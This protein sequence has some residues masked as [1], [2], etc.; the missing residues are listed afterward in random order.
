MAAAGGSVLNQVAE[1]LGASEPALKLILSIF[2]GYPLALFQRYFL[3][4][5]EPSHIHLFNTV[6]GLGIA[7][8]NFG[9]Q[10]YHSLLCVVLNFLILRLMGRTITAVLTSFCFQMG[11]LLCGYYY[12]ATENYDIKWTMPQ[13]VLTLK[14]IGLT[15]D[16]YDGGKEQES[17]TE[18]QKRFAVPGVPSLIEV[19]GFSYYYGG[20]LVGPQF[21]MCSYLKLVRGELTDVPGQRP[22]S[23]GP[24]MNRLCLGLFSLVIYTVF[25][26]HLPDSYF[27]TDEFANQPFWYRCAYIPIWGKVILYKY[28]TCWLVTEGVCI[29]SGLGYNGKDDTG[30]AQWDAC[31]NMK[32]W[33]FETTP[34]FTGT[35]SSF[36]INTNAWVARYIFKRLRFL[37]N[38][39]I[40]QAAALF[41]L[42]I[43]HGLHSGYF[44]CF[45]LE[46]LIVI[47]ERQAVELIRDSPLLSHICSIPLLRPVIYVLQQC[48]HWLFM[49]YPL[50]P[51]CLF[52]WDKWLKVYMS[53]YFIGHVFFLLLLFALPYLRRVLVP[54]K[55][56][57]KSQ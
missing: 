30:R 25:G 35:I 57:Q 34:L 32:V 49:G 43:W 39:A 13:C 45:S 31:A 11:Y 19:C 17:L 56:K 51:F 15:F 24:A 12:T 53:V 6:T 1:A 2:L 18:E 27:L 54:R 4:K 40:S 23:I 55:D 36:N 48:I 50:I 33:Q 47:V 14:L 3:Y 37:G 41:F 9:S 21:S 46:F 26:P 10:L 38:K 20:F 16:Y 28:V 44:I 22:N 8:F 52:T 42:A 7:Y 5:K 29:L